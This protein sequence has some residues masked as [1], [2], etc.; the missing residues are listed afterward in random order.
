MS[1]WIVPSLM[2]LGITAF[3]ALVLLRARGQG[4]PAAAYDLRVY[5]EQLKEMERDLARGLIAQS[6]A[7][8]VR[9]EISRRI[10][11]A[12]AQLQQFNAGN[13]Q[14]RNLSLIVVAICGA[15]MIAGSLMLYRAL[16]APG[17]GDLSLSTRLE[18]AELNRTSRPSQA[19]VEARMPPQPAPEV[20][21]SYGELVSKLRETVEK[22]PQDIEGH[23]L[24]SRHEANLGNYTAAYAAKSREIELLQSEAGPEQF[25]EQAQLMI[26]AAGGYVSPEAETA[27]RTALQIDPTYGPARYYWGLMMDQIGRPDMAFQIWEQTLRRS[28][29]D[30][31]WLVP[32]RAQI[33][34]LAW[35][36]G[37]KYELAAAPGAAA[38]PGPD[39]GAVAAAQS[40]SDA[41][42]QEMIQ[43]MVNQLSDR[44][45]TEGGAPDE[46]ARLI[47]ALGVLGDMDRARAI[48]D[49]ASQK[50]ADNN[51]AMMLIVKAGIQAGVVE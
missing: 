7:D 27:L 45:A 51:E 15:A 12:D 30:A 48:Y 11:A 18:M 29:P 8:R 49:E 14:P 4:E 17:Y 22:R 32:I 43:G 1:F 13:Q 28:P 3:L 23:A 50:F 31:P 35:K 39:A 34:E 25:G 42:R 36:A 44:L 20:E 41:D 26:L 40:M 37:V 21:A 46:W 47:G 2:A 5:R 16:G 19:D 33:E 38:L 6:D 10:L 24:L 9:T